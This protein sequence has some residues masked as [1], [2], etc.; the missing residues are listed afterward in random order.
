MTFTIASLALALAAA[1][2]A[3]PL[4]KSPAATSPARPAAAP[5]PAAQPAP[6][7]R[8]SA[9]APASPAEPPRFRIGLR[10]GSFV[11]RTELA[12]GPLGALEAAYLLPFEP[13]RNRLRVSLSAGYVSV[14]QRS[15]KIV[16]GRGFDQGF[17]QRT[18][19]VPIELAATWDLLVPAA[20]SPGVAA[21]V[22]YGLYPTSTQFTAFNTPTTERAA[23]QAA[24]AVAR[25]S[26]PLG[27]GLVFLDVRYAEARASLGPLG[28]VGTSDLSGFALAAGYSL[29]L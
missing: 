5:A 7:A 29:D 18:T 26:L 22:G 19:I 3:P 10:L 24:F 15:Q 28:D 1:P 12:A 27:P 21:G 16:P 23:G 6:V 25:G 17:I 9:K 4:G 20:G 11:P 8:V 2:Q 14:A 13:L